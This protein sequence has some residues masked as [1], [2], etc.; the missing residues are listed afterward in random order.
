MGHLKIEL[1]ENVVSRSILVHGTRAIR[2]ASAAM[3]LSSACGPFAPVLLEG[4]C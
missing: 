4:A 1:R 2:W 3:A